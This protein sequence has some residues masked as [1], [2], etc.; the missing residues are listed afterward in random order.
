[1]SRI[2]LADDSP[3]AQRMGELILREEGY[4]VVTITDGATVL[5]RLPDVDPDLI[6]VD[7]TMP[8]KSGYEICEFVKTSL[9]HVHTRVVLVA[10]AM[11]PVDDQ[12]VHRVR[13]DGVL[14]KPFE[15]SVVLETVKPLLLA[16]AAAR[17]VAPN[18]G[19]LKEIVPARI[20]SG[21]ADPELIRA[22]VTI[23]LDASLPGLIEEITQKVLVALK[24]E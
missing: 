2:L 8:T 22:A 21:G 9:R 1:M 23:A 17:E 18:P 20:P 10:G 24:A 19:S 12:E 14:K 6:L 3:H 11:D 5:L 4:E 15:S 16:A 13:A 7:V